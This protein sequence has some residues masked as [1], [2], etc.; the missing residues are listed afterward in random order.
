MKAN[1]ERDFSVVLYIILY[2]QVILTV[3]F[4]DESSS[5]TIQM[6]ATEQYFPVVPIIMLL[7]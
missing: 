7:F 5:V 1:F 6:K 2:N 3:E 4:V